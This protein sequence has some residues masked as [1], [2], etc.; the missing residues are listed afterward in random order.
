MLP[1]LHALFDQLHTE[2]SGLGCRFC[3]YAFAD[4]LTRQRLD[5]LPPGR[6]RREKLTELLRDKLKGAG[7]GNG[8]N[9]LL[10]GVSGL[11][12]LLLVVFIILGPKVRFWLWVSGYLPVPGLVRTRWFMRQRCFPAAPGGTFISFAVELAADTFRTPEQRV[13]RER[14]LVDAFLHDLRLAYRRRL[15]RPWAWRRT[16]RVL[17]LLDNVADDPR[18]Q[19]FLNLVADVRNTSR[20]ADPL[21]LVAGYRADAVPPPPLAAANATDAFDT[22]NTTYKAWRRAEPPGDMDWRLW[23][24]VPTFVQAPPGLTIGPDAEGWGRHLSAPPPPIW[25]RRRVLVSL[26]LVVVLLAGGVAWYKTPGLRHHCRSRAGVSV[27]W[28]GGQCVGYSDGSYKF[29]AGKTSEPAR[30]LLTVQ[31]KIAEQNQCAAKL[32]N[33][34]LGQLPYGLGLMTLVYFA[35]LTGETDSDWTAAQVAELEGLL[36][37]QRALN[38]V[39]GA[40]GACAGTSKN[41]SGV[42]LRI[43]IA[44]GGNTMRYADQVARDHLVPLASDSEENVLGVI[45]MDRSTQRTG[46]AVTTLGNAG[47]PVVATTLSG[48]GMQI[49]SPFYFQL[50]PDNR[51]QA[52]LVANYAVKNAKKNIYIYYPRSPT[53]PAGQGWPAVDDFYVS[54]LVHDVQEEAMRAGLTYNLRGWAPKEN[55]RDWFRQQCATIQQPDDL[56]FFAGRYDNFHEFAEGMR[57]CLDRVLADDSVSRYVVQAAGRNST[58]AF[59]FVSKG[60]P[61]LLASEDCFRGNLT[62]GPLVTDSLRDFC[63]RLNDM[64]RATGMSTP[65][66]LW[67]DERI[68]LAYDAAKLF[69]DIV[70]TWGPVTKADIGRRLRE[71]FPGKEEKCEDTAFPAGAWP[72][73]TGCV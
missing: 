28:V 68:G 50:V 26:T 72:G 23:L 48:D 3:T 52:L 2:P 12:R 24:R 38:Q 27:S 51:R 39:Q 67:P 31:Q 9:P 41:P 29:N 18:G 65:G 55:T 14:L 49:F 47:V 37:W 16:A 10:D 70:E 33:L 15:W 46:Q 66:T 7:N 62:T 42:A 71:A 40:S 69:V 57:S 36:T 1:V 56:I 19:Q 25:A 30:Q 6:A 45:G 53:D 43:I 8:T 11:A 44:N 35:G 63:L 73:A 60:A 64:Y 58:T 22:W 13:Q 54:T 4:W 21:L 20:K 32:H 59:R 61:V 5:P 17:V 34:P